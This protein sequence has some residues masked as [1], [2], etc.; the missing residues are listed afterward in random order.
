VRARAPGKVVLSGA[1][2]V[3]YGAPAV[4][5]AVSRYAIA[6]AARPADFVTPEVRSALGEAPA[7]WFDASALRGARGKLGLGSSA[8]ILVACLAAQA[9][10]ARSPGDDESLARAVLERALAAHRS[11]QGGGSGVDVATSVWGRTL[12]ARRSGDALATERVA[13]PTG[14][15]WEVWAGGAPASTAAFVGRVAELARRE[16]KLFAGLMDPL[17][18]QAEAAANAFRV[19]NERELLARLRAQRAGLEALGRAAEI[20]IVTPEVAELAELAEQ[21]GAVVLPSGAGGGDVEIYAGTAPPS[22][23]LAARRA[24]LGH[25]RLELELDARGV[26]ALD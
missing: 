26:H 14:L 6:N 21:D 15:V 20:P 16:A 12:I 25:E 3:L 2:A 19:G 4:V 10:A 18:E 5:S 13:L 1:Y 9:L 7:P 11:A 17:C 24:A 22:S 8:A 23:A